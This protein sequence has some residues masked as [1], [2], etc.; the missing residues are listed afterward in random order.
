MRDTGT[1]L[2][3]FFL[4]KEAISIMKNQYRHIRFRY[5]MYRVVGLLF[6]LC[7]HLNQIYISLNEKE[8][9][10]R[11]MKQ[12]DSK[13]EFSPKSLLLT[14]LKHTNFYWNGITYID[15]CILYKILDDFK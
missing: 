3:Q 4:S 7:Y 2:I 11:N 14:I 5:T 12:I 9:E 8:I 13:N 6:Y 10:K 1:H 15:I